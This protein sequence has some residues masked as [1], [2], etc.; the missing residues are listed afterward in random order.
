MSN[1]RFKTIKL[2]EIQ[3]RIIKHAMEYLLINADKELVCE[4]CQKRLMH[5]IDGFTKR[6]EGIT[7]TEKINLSRTKGNE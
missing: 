3:Q 7:L 2:G 6:T 5:L 4:Y 1:K